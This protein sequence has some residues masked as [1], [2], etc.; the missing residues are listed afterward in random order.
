MGSHMPRNAF[1]WGWLAMGLT[2]VLAAPFLSGGR[3]AFFGWTDDQVQN[4]IK[5]TRTIGVVML[6][7]YAIGSLSS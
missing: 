7:F 4:G 6:V 2:V 1:E 5:V 3:G